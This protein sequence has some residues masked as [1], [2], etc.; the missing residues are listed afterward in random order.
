M[1][2]CGKATPRKLV[3]DVVTERGDSNLDGVI[4]ATD[5]AILAANFGYV[6]PTGVVPKPVT[7]SLLSLGGLALL[8]RKK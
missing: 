1:E 5:L 3:V 2:S 4:N 6:A 7:V 8:K